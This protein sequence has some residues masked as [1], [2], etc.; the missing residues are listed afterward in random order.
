MVSSRQH[1]RSRVYILMQEEY[2]E[3]KKRRRKSWRWLNP[4]FNDQPATSCRSRLVCVGHVT[5]SIPTWACGYKHP[6]IR[7]PLPT[8]NFSISHPSRL[9][10]KTLFHNYITE[11][12]HREHPRHTAMASNHAPSNLNLPPISS[13]L[14][15]HVIISSSHHL[16]ISSS[17]HL[18]ISSSHRPPLPSLPSIT[19]FL[20]CLKPVATISGSYSPRCLSKK[21]VSSSRC[22]LL[23]RQGVEPCSIAIFLLEG[24]L[25]RGDYTNRYTSEDDVCVDLR[26]VVRRSDLSRE[27]LQWSRGLKAMET[28][29]VSRCEGH[30]RPRGA[31][32]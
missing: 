9:C 1:R 18:I 17:H 26:H 6:T 11:K 32:R 4:K 19:T 12:R 23:L 27:D 7:S 15:F 14:F 5:P 28:K 30:V 13:T 25:L 29:A 21:R 20:L 10:I 24:S 31:L 3:E 16:I 2:E 22:S 8:T